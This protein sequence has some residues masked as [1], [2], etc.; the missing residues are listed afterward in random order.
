[1]D[2]YKGFEVSSSGKE[3]EIEWIKRALLRLWGKNSVIVIVIVIV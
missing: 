3:E 1:M 2:P